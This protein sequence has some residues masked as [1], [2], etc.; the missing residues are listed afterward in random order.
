MPESNSLLMGSKSPLSSVCKIEKDGQKDKVQT[1]DKVIYQ[2]PEDLPTD[3]ETVVAKDCSRSNLWTVL[4]KKEWQDKLISVLLPDTEIKVVPQSYSPKLVIN[5][6]ELS[7]RDDETKEIVL[8]IKTKDSQEYRSQES[9]EEQMSPVI[10]ELKKKEKTISIVSQKLGLKVITD[11]KDVHIEALPYLSGHL[12]G[13]CGDYNGD[14]HREIPEWSQSSSKESSEEM[15]TSIEKHERQQVKKGE[16][17]VTKFTINKEQCQIPEYISQ[18]Q[19]D[20]MCHTRP[21]TVVRQQPEQSKTC[22][23]LD[24]VNTCKTPCVSQKSHPQ[25]VSFHCLPSK[26]AYTQYLVEEAK[27]RVITEM[28]GES[29]DQQYQVTV[30]ERCRRPH[31]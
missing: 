30:D 3:C 22:F 26:D 19:D 18:S 17:M 24:P 4:M 1:F 15:M 6:E 8:D 23:T 10:V 14:S 20:G 13:L 27:Y 2:L 28:K 11:G 21:M 5:D 31:Y 7:L 9:S 29:A 25:T 12:C 16:Q